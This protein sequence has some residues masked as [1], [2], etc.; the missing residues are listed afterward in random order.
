M[1]VPGDQSTGTATARAPHAVRLAY[2]AVLA[3]FLLM[4]AVQ[5]FLAGLGAFSRGSGPGFEPHRILGFAMSG[6]ALLIVVL[7]LPARA[8]ARSIGVAVLLFLLAAG[9]QSLLAVLADDSA[10]FGGVHAL[11]GL[12]L[13]GLAGFLQ[14]DARRVAP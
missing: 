1:T 9:G 7:A 6:V 2:R 13:L 3:G 14:S 11:A 12:A 5:I 4:G 8:G 10:F